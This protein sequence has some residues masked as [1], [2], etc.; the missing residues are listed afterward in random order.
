MTDLELGFSSRVHTTL[1]ADWLCGPM[2]GAIRGKLG[3]LTSSPASHLLPDAAKP[4]R[5]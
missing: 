1:G 4:F 5:L 3:E 2:G